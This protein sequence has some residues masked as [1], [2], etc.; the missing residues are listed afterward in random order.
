[1]SKPSGKLDSLQREIKQESLCNVAG[2]VNLSCKHLWLS[3]YQILLKFNERVIYFLKA[4]ILEVWREITTTDVRTGD[5]MLFMLV[6]ASKTNKQIR[7]SI[8]KN[9]GERTKQNVKK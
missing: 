2:K 7:S 5:I 1:M 4:V 6:M 3:K 9:K 8:E